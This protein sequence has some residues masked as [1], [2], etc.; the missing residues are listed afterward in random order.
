MN[1]GSTNHPDKE[2]RVK[3][4]RKRIEKRHE[5]TKRELGESM[6][7]EQGL[8]RSA[9]NQITESLLHLDRKKHGGIKDVTDLRVTMDTKEAKRRVNEDSTRKERLNKLQKE[10]F[11]S[12]K[13][14]AAIEMRWAELL[15]VEIPQDLSEEMQRQMQACAEVINSKDE[16]IVGFQRQLRTKDEEYVRALNKQSQDFDTLLERIRQEFKTLQFEYDNELRSI[17]DSFSDERERIIMELVQE[18]DH[19][20]ENR[21]NKE[22][23]FKDNKQKRED[24]Y[25]RDVEDLITKGASQYNKL[26]IELEMNIQTL[27]Q[28]LQEIKA[29]YQ[30]NTEKLDYNYRVLTELDVEKKSELTRLKRRLAKLKDQLSIL[31]TKYTDTSDNDKKTNNDLTNDYRNLTRKYKDLQAKFRHFEVSDTNKYD[32]IWMMHEDE[33]KDLVDKLLKADK[34]ITEYQMGWQ[35]NAPNVTALQQVLGK[36]AG[37]LVQNDQENTKE[38]NSTNIPPN[39]KDQ[40]HSIS[41]V[42]IRGMLQLLADQAGFLMNTEVQNVIETIPESDINLGR[43]ESMLK[44]LG[45]KNEESLS[46]L[47]KYFFKENKTA[48]MISAGDIDEV[49]RNEEELKFFYP[50][51]GT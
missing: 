43:A 49:E 46:K 21:R 22:T 16:L 31:V 29:T 50:D 18:I 38:S 17:E 25:Q 7:S 40:E 42:R 33:A 6:D 39:M 11:G 9:A 34:I 44:T 19:L 1:E 35:W 51:E 15:E 41:G 30:L 24:Q 26:K 23:Q 14:N 27:K 10:A 36:H 5:D 13:A 48:N 2:E 47:S 12:A 8:N 37:V 28:Q 20:F 45:V 32:E 3:A 4:R